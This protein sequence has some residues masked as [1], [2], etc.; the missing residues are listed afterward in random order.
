MLFFDT[1]LH[2]TIVTGASCASILR[3]RKHLGLATNGVHNAIC[4][5]GVIPLAGDRD[6]VVTSVS[7][8]GHTGTVL[9]SLFRNRGL[10]AL[11][12]DLRGNGPILYRIPRCVSCSSVEYAAICCGSSSVV[13]PRAVKCIGG[14]GVN[15]DKLRLTCG[16]VLRDSDSICFDCTYSTLNGVLRN[17]STSI[18][19]SASTIAGNIMA[20]LSIGVRDVVRRAS[21]PLAGNTV[22]ITSTSALGV[23]NVISHPGFSPS[24]IRG[25]LSSPSSPLFG[26]TVGSCTINSTF[27]PYVT[28][29]TVRGNLLNARCGYMNGVRVVSQGFDYRG[30]DKRNALGLHCTLTGSYGACFCGLKVGAKT[31]GICGV[32]STLDFNGGVGLY[33]KVCAT[34]DGVPTLSA[35]GGSTCLTGFDVKRNRFSTAPV[36]VLALCSTVTGGKGCCVPSVIRKVCGGSDF[37]RCGGNFPAETVDRRATSAL[38]SCL[39]AMVGRNANDST[40]PRAIATTNGA[41]A[42]RAK[43]FSGNGRVLED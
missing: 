42:T 12:G 27:G 4:S 36:S 20:A 31:S 26:H 7:P 6:G 39:R 10:S 40:L 5:Y 38:G 25:C 43:V 32:T 1:F 21:G 17:I 18:C 24:G 3:A 16:S 22:I 15:I 28:T 33:S 35:L 8:A 37:R 11:L 9:P 19:G 34:G 23:H 30:G 14:R 2:I 29:T 41:T 13:T